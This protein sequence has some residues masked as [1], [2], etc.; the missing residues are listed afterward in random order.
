M[1]IIPLGTEARANLGFSHKVIITYADLTS[2]AANQTLTFL[3]D[4]TTPGQLPAGFAVMRS[5]YRLIT[6]FTGSTISAATLDLGDKA[7]A[8]RYIAANATDLYTASGTNTK[9]S[10]V[11]TTSYAFSSKDVADTNAQ[12]TAKISATGA[13]VNA[14]TAGRLEIYLLLGWMADGDPIT[15][16][17]ITG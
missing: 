13:N 1:K 16:P 6:P 9:D 7:S 4:A 11:S 14:A 12:L 17:G 3:P 2:A 15:E 5:G 10:V 8:S